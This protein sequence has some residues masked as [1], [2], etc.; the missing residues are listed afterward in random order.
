MSKALPYPK[1]SFALPV[2]LSLLSLCISQQ[3]YATDNVQANTLAATSVPHATLDTIVI[4]GSAKSGTALAQKISEMPAVTQMI[5]EDEIAAQITGN[6]SLAD[7]LGQLVPSIGTAS[8]STSNYGTTM[9][10]RPVQYLLNGVPLSGSRDLSRQLNSIDPTQLERIEVLSGSTSI[11]GAGASG[12]LINF[13]TKSVTE[14]GFHGQSRIGV[15]SNRDFNEESFGFNVGQTL[16]FASSD[17]AINARLDVDYEEKGG[18]FDSKGDRVSPEVYQTDQQD[19]DT[20]SVNANIGWNLSDSQSINLAATHYDNQQDTEYGPDYGSNF[21]A[22]LGAE[23]SYDAVKGLKLETQPFTTK[24]TLNL[25]YHNDDILGSNLNVTGYYREESA[26]FYPSPIPITYND[27]AKAQI[28]TLPTAYQA[29]IARIPY[30]ILQSTADIEV[31]GIRAAMQTATNLSTMPTLLSYGVDYENEYDEQHY[32][33]H[34]LAKFFAS[35]GLVAKL[36]G[37]K[38]DAG[39]DTDIDKLGVFANA[40]IDVTDN[41]HVSGGVRYQNLQAETQSF[42]P[43]SDSLPE[44]LLGKFGVDYKPDSVAAGKTD[45][46]KTLFNVGT[47]YD[48]SPQ[49]Q[50]FA[51]FSQGFSISDIQRALRDVP[52]DFVI[53]SDNVDP[54][55]VNGYELGWSGKSADTT[56]KLVGFYNDSDKTVRFTSDYKVL[57]V[58]TDERVYGAEAAISHDLN[59]QWTLGSTLAYT[60]G[61]YQDIDGTWRELNAVRLTPLK[62]TAFAQYNF[63]GG[64][65]IR[66]QALA[67]GGTDKAYE[68]NQARPVAARAEYKLNAKPVDGFLV[69]DLVGQVKLPVGHLDYGIYN[70]ANT[71]YKTVYNQTTYGALNRLDAA[72]TT[73]GLGYTIDY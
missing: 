3:L 27:R 12:G 19:T 35:N 67:I 73:Y 72:G 45:H 1:L 61:Q 9:H 29:Q 7:V 63:D 5:Y 18:K 49:H 66:L 37:S 59:D 11:Y 20:I 52:T 30:A 22:L 10:G 38:F 39:P 54:I 17:N 8:G 44:Y 26:R 65:S 57:V 24:N 16:G 36:N 15:N 69:A 23:P 64:S 31:M 47:S 6:R 2:S 13:V 25:N 46:S 33:G 32:Y 34:D 60:R 51:N 14:T 4:K 21:S 48:L 62:G 43:R 42:T 71:Q 68:D 28:A 58:D 53:N 56:A 55:T 41:W 70:I 40:D 50:V